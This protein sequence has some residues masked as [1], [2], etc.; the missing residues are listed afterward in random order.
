MLAVAVQDVVHQKGL[1]KR[2]RVD[3]MQMASCVFVGSTE[4]MGLRSF[5]AQQNPFFNSVNTCCPR[6]SLDDGQ[7]F[8]AAFATS[9][10]LLD[11]L[12]VIMCLT[13][14]PPPS[15]IQPSPPTPLEIER[16]RERE[17]ERDTNSNISC[18]A[19]CVFNDFKLQPDTCTNHTSVVVCCCV[20]CV[21]VCFKHVCSP[22]S[23]PNKP[24]P[25]F[26]S[27]P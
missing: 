2:S 5:G 26:D 12:N 18:G 23:W 9:S 8:R 13:Y 15:S 4:I 14:L 22:E 20:C 24:F 17:S 19:R 10:E 11:Y 16:E 3:I 7:L 21:C 1:G 27:W 6:Q 25:K